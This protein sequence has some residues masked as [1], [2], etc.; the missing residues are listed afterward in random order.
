MR[1]RPKNKGTVT[2]A[3]RMYTRT[4][5]PAG[6]SRDRSC[7]ENS[8]PVLWFRTWETRNPRVDPVV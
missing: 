2:A 1:W 6:C 7:A 3:N 8:F 5:R 4:V